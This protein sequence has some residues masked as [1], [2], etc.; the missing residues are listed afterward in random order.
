MT[1]LEQPKKP[2]GGAFGVFAAEQ[3]PKFQAQCAG[4]PASE[5]SKLAG[6]AW[7]K[8]GE[9]ERAKYQAKYEEA[10]TQFDQ[11]M[12]DFKSKGGEV[13]PI[14]RKSKGKRVKDENAPKRPVGGAYGIFLAENR[15]DVRRSLPDGN[16]VTAVTKAVSGRW[17]A[18]PDEEKKPYEERSSRR[19]WRSTRR[20][21]RSTK[22]L[23]ARR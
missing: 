20:P 21:W 11:K 14:V 22:Q 23:R 8:L 18:L 19:R 3:R 5:V 4:R 6:E 13:A 9:D 15:D 17:K 12:A 16:K 2:V 7:K 10:K 1:S